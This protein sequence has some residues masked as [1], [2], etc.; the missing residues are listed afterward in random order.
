MLVNWRRTIAAI[1]MMIFMVPGVTQMILSFPGITA[2]F[3]DVSTWCAAGTASCAVPAKSHRATCL[4]TPSYCH[5]WQQKVC[6]SIKNQL[7]VT[8]K[9][10][11][12]AA[13]AIYEQGVL[14]LDQLGDFKTYLCSRSTKGLLQMIK[15]FPA[16]LAIEWGL[17]RDKELSSGQNA[18]CGLKKPRQSYL[19]GYKLLCVICLCNFKISHY[20]YA[21][22]YM[23]YK[24]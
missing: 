7:C 22:V 2:L 15:H 20:I 13:C 21:E 24:D 18:G 14:F 1:Q 19:L 5:L 4:C 3:L 9:E 17:D 23:C 12:E 8:E 16:D 11:T 10:Q 6:D